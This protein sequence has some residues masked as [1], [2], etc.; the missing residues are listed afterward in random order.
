MGLKKLVGLE[1]NM[2]LIVEIEFWFRCIKLQKNLTSTLMR[3]SKGI[4]DV[5]KSLREQRT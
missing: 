5:F 3:I 4:T 1:F 2:A